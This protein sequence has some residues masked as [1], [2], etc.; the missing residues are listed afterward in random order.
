M[1]RL[2]EIVLGLSIVLV[3]VGCSR[4]PTVVVGDSSGI[5]H[6]DR[7]TGVLEILWEKHIQTVDTL[8]KKPTPD[9]ANAQN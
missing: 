9:S 8:P 6:Y 4:W 3:F 5:L 7:A 2:F 1:K